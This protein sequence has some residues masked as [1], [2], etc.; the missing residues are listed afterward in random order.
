MEATFAE[1]RTTFQNLPGQKRERILEAAVRE[2]AARGYGKAS[3][4]T[5][6]AEA[7]IAKGSVYQYFRNKEDLFLHLADRFVLLV[8]DAV[9]RAAAAPATDFFGQVRQVFL[10]GIGFLR[11]EPAF[12]RFYLRILSDEEAPRREE[13]IS[14]VRLFPVDY[15]G[16]LCEVARARGEIRRELATGMVIF[17]LDALLDRFLQGI[18]VAG[19]GCGLALNAMTEEQLHAAVD[20]LIGML[21][22]GLA[23]APP[24]G[25]LKLET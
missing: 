6:V 25:N 7:G 21:R 3:V 5:I 23:S 2:F 20:T 11:E 24:R 12:F 13:L 1:P 4:N 22:N 14:R 9:R 8:K 17:L 15:F 16:P 18:A 19:T 10:A